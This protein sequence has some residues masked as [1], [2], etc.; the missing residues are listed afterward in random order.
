MTVTDLNPSADISFQKRIFQTVTKI[1][2]NITNPE[3][4]FNFQFSDP[5]CLAE[6]PGTLT[7]EL[8]VKE[9]KMEQLI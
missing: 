9:E 6:L 8:G 1:Q 5:A 3:T 2:Q 7:N 4:R